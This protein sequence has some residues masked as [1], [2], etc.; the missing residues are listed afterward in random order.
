MLKDEHAALSRRQFVGKVATGAAG[1]AVAVSVVNSKAGATAHHE[2]KT[3]VV[4]NDAAQPQT[5][6]RDEPQVQSKPAAPPPW[7]LLQPL[8]AGSDLAEGWKVKELSGIVDGSCVLTLENQRGRTNRLHICRNS[9]NPE[10]LV[11]TDRLDLVVMNGGRGDMPTEEGLGRAVA[12]VAHVLAANEKRASSI[13]KE[14]LPQQ[15]RLA[16]FADTARLR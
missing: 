6:V 16:M 8:R 5:D 2:R 15:Q 4:D 14:L 9:G 3:D 10:G 11:F 12:E 13:V 7:E 1:A